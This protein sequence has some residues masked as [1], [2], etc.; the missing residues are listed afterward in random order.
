VLDPFGNVLGVM[1]NQHY[2]DVLATRSGGE[3]A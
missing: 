2:H 1:L 3:H